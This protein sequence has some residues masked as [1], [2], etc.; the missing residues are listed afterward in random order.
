MI[1]EDC[2][3]VS[4]IFL[5]ILHHGNEEVQEKKRKRKEEL[6]K[7]KQE[8]KERLKIAK[9]ERLE[10]EKLERERAE[11]ERL[12]QERIDREKQENEKTNEKSAFCDSQTVLQNN[13]VN[14]I[15]IAD[16]LENIG[17]LILILSII[18]CGIGILDS[19]IRGNSNRSIFIGILIASF[20]VACVFWG[21]AKVIELL[22]DIS[23]SLKKNNQVASQNF[24][25]ENNKDI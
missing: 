17:W 8:E 12:E 2:I 6:K 20:I 18:I 23:L 1:N 13:G 3:F 9:Q 19:L 5:I 4:L 24:T 25:R 16:R 11:K 15:K 10:Q 7:Q 21:F 14:N 22:N